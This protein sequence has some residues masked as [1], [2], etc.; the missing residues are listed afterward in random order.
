V[1]FRAQDGT[2]VNPVDVS[3]VLREFPLVQHELSQGRDGTCSLKVRTLDPEPGLQD[4]LEESLHR[5]FGRLTIRVD[6]DP[7]LGD[8][9]GS[10]KVLPYHS[11]WLLEE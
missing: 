1:I 6:F 9:A 5:L 3:R 7:H 4:R 11:E 10:G 2:L 8:R